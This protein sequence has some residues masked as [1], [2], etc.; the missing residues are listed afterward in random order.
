MRN[1]VSDPLKLSNIDYNVVKIRFIILI[2][3]IVNTV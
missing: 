1:T 3:L 2:V